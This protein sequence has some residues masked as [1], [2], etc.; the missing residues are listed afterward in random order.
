MKT[1][2]DPFESS[3]TKKNSHSALIHPSLKYKS[4]MIFNI[5]PFVDDEGQEPDNE[6]DDQDQESRPHGKHH[7][8]HHPRGDND[9]D[10]G[11]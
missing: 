1:N 8:R 5:F 7:R 2:K 4:N 10:N 11:N 6:G 3:Q 9:D